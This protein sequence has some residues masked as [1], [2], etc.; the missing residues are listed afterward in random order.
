MLVATGYI[1]PLNLHLC[2][3][4]RNAPPAHLLTT[5]IC[6]SHRVPVAL[7]PSG[8]PLFASRPPTCILPPTPVPLALPANMVL[9]L[10]TLLH[11]R[12][13]CPRMGRHRPLYWLAWGWAGFG[14][15][16]VDLRAAPAYLSHPH[17][18]HFVPVAPD[19][20][21]PLPTLPPARAPRFRVLL[22]LL[23]FLRRRW[24]LRHPSPMCAGTPRPD[25]TA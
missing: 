3:R 16:H 2:A 15:N 20:R 4:S 8:P 13:N 22:V 21:G 19:L 6:P 23:P 25:I 7:P 18:H 11:R 9:A 10:P 1:L 12:A 17:T 5:A 24:P 14:L